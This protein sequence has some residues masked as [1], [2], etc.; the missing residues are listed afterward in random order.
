MSERAHVHLTGDGS[1]NS[2]IKAIPAPADFLS[3]PVCWDILDP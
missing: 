2:A 3:G 1:G